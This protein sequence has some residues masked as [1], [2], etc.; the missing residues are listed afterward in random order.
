MTRPVDPTEVL[1]RFTGRAPIFPLP[2]VVHFPHLL[3]PLH[4]FEPRYRRMVA[5]ALEGDR[6]L[7][8]ALLKPGWEAASFGARPAVF[9]MVCLGRISAEQR[10]SD[11]RYYLVL[12]GL[13]RA[14]ITDEEELDL[15]YRTARMKLCRDVYTA[16]PA[17]ERDRWRSQLLDAFRK[18]HPDLDLETV[19]RHALECSV[20]LGVLCD[21]LADA[22]RLPPVCAQEV[23]ATVNVGER[24]ALVMKRM[25]ERL[26]S[27][28]GRQKRTFP[29]P[30]SC[31]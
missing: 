21:V 28:C 18:L 6:L 17:V 11:G 13:S 23:L 30:F 12:Q 15:P 22:L 8:M 27:R 3:L 24:C 26:A 29:P 16:S 10:L 4:I 5:D 31:N 9:D 1:E 20:P 25:Q 2:N 14:R 19:F 7:A